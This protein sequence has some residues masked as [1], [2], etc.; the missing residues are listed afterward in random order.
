MP[1]NTLQDR[2]RRVRSMSR[3]ELMVRSRQELSKRTDE[4][5]SRVGYDFAGKVTVDPS[6]ATPAHFFFTSEQVPSIIAALTARLPR[7][8]DDIV[9]RASRICEH[10]FDLLGFE[11][12]NFGSEIDWH[13]DPVHK[14]RAPRAVF[15]KVPYLDFDQCGDVKITWEL[16]R[17]QHFVTLAKAYCVTGDEKFAAELFQQWKH[18]HKENPYPVGVN[19]ASSLEVA[20]RSL[21][22]FWAHALVKGSKSKPAGFD[23]EYVRAQGLNGRHLERY[24]STYFSA[25]THLMG[26]GVALFFLGTLLPQLKSAERWQ[27]LGWQIVLEEAKNQVRADGFHFEQSTYYHVYAIDFFLHAAVLAMNNAVALP[28]EFEGTIQKMLNALCLLA[29]SG[30]VPRLGDDDGGRLFDGRRNRMEHLLDPLAAGAVLFGRGDFKTAAGGLTEETVWLL[31]TPG[32]AEFDRIEEKAPE[33]NSTALPATGLYV[34]SDPASRLQV[35]IDAGPLGAGTGGHGHADALSLTISDARGPLLIDPGTLEYVGKGP[36]RNQYRG[37]AAHN[38]LLVDDKDQADPKGP[39][40]WT[41][42]PTARVEKWINGENFD[43][44]VGSHDGY[45]RLEQPVVHRRW[46]FSLKS[47]FVLIR[48]IAEG[49][50][51]H[52]LDLYWHIAPD[53]RSQGK[54][55][56]G[57]L[58][59]RGERG[60]FTTPVEGHGWAQDVRQGSWSPAYG[61]AE[62]SAILHFGTMAAL[63]AEFVT[64]LVPVVKANARAGELTRI[65]EASDARV[66]R[67]YRYSTPTREHCIFF[68]PENKGWVAGPWASDAEFVYSGRDRQGSDRTVIFYN[69]SHVTLGREKL[70]ECARKISRYELIGSGSEAKVF[71]SNR[72][73]V[74]TQE[75]SSIEPTLASEPVAG[76]TSN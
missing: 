19:W 6:R 44:F 51:K 53:L 47:Q 9:R 71:S 43:L 69:G 31:G 16:N 57:F 41:T 55:S 24:L 18:W 7:E 74:L 68:A 32:V 1:A 15:H 10:R 23:D 66:V 20:F 28:A 13:L 25:N 64:L 61:K 49:E 54:R 73:A 40:A 60:I 45:R 8:L 30:S 70:V 27:K 33:T 29:R 65:S 14:K 36:E 21:S 56:E 22:W 5:L 76:G 26:E 11:N 12:L 72:D 46:V 48:D 59:A 62:R 39:F 35:A 17:H 50:G 63:P 3:H 52:R 42:L 38:T 34:M 67:G 2:W 4:L 37:T 75:T 58:D